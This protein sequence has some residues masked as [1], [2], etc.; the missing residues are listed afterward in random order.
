MNWTVDRISLWTGPLCWI[1]NCNLCSC[2]VCKLPTNHHVFLQWL[3][4]F[5]RTVCRW[6]QKAFK[7]LLSSLVRA[8]TVSVGAAKA[9]LIWLASIT[10][11]PF[12]WCLSLPLLPPFGSSTDLTNLNWFMNWGRFRPWT[13]FMVCTVSW[14][15]N[16]QESPFSWFEPIPIS[17]MPPW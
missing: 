15:T 13:G 5:I 9:F 11:K 14:T 17:T 10:W 4:Q 7:C 1:A 8:A 2:T 6:A 16:P 3:I 12:Q